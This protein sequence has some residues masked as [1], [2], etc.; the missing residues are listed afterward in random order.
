MTAMRTMFFIW[1][2]LI[3][4]GIVTYAVIGLSHG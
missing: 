2:F 4:F 3:A 1:S